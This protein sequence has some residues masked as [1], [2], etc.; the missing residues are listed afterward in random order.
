MSDDRR[1]F[2]KKVAGVAAALTGAQTLGGRAGSVPSADAAIAEPFVS[3]RF[4][5]DLD[6]EMAGFLKSVEGGGATAEV[7]E[8]LE[9]ESCA[10]HKHLANVKYEDI[11]LA[12]GTGMSAA[13]YE[14][15][16]GLSKCGAERRSGAIV[17]ATFDYK[18][19]ARTEFGMPA[20]DVASKSP[21]L[22]N[23]TLAPES[24]RRVKPGGTVK[25]CGASKAQKQ[26]LASNFRLAI[27][28]L[29]CK[30][31]NKIEAITLRQTGGDRERPRLEIPNLVLTLPESGAE[32]FYQWHEDFVINGKSA[33]ERKGTLE[34][35]T[36][37]LGQALF[38]LEFENLGIFRL[39]SDK[40]EANADQIRRVTA[41]M[42]CEEIR[43]TF[44]RAAAG[45]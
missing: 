40:G 26:W 9:A 4:V 20:L 24:T 35:L 27:D 42:Y 14:W 39:T 38:T 41:E 31:V 2:F 3:G 19:V 34:Y 13:F 18:E 1:G 43:F 22:M 7:V 21:A 33:D 6:G 15:L 11:S 5:L 29:D 30:T 28:G 44:A 16:Q 37:N 25:P 36:P 12:C 17:A 8:I 10:V 23:V 32:S 45:C